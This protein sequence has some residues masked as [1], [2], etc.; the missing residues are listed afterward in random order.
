MRTEIIAEIGQNHN[1]DME[2]AKKLIHEAKRAGA[3][4]AKFQLYEA[5][6]LFPKEGNAWF[7]YNCK[8]ELSRDQIKVLAQECERADIEFMAS[9]FDI[10]RIQW[11]EEVGMKRYKIASRSIF[12]DKLVEAVAATAKPM[13]VSLGKWD[14][15]GLPDIRA[16]GGVDYL[17]CIAKY[18]PALSE[19]HLNR[20][21][22]NVYAGFSDHT[23]GTAASIAAIA[24]SARIIEKHFTL[25]K[26]MIGP[27]HAGS[28]TPA[29]L[30]QMCTFRDE[31]EEILA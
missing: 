30:A 16:T 14:R 11:L 7:D 15:P 1:G 13:I 22:F 27:D 31:A 4:V 25:D 17:Y 8:T 9:V 2:L 28:A 3:D 21:D 18:P 29:E 26:A 23:I 6:A 20:A 24:R 5:R 12:D 10:E 19:V